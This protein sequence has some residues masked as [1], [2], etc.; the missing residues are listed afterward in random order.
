MYICD[1]AVSNTCDGLIQVADLCGNELFIA[2]EPYTI[3]KS[4][5][6]AEPLS[7]PKCPPMPH[8]GRIVGW[9]RGSGACGSA[10]RIPRAAVKPERP[11]LYSA[12]PEQSN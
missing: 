7:A 11:S 12:D 6:A 9:A 8:F 4:Q 1:I 3:R 10:R 2:P 5:L